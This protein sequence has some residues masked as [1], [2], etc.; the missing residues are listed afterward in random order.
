[1]D[2]HGMERLFSWRAVCLGFFTFDSQRCSPR[3]ERLCSIKRF[4]RLGRPVRTL[5][6]A[7]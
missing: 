6:L 1:M 4:C 7:Y 2:I 3:A 5:E